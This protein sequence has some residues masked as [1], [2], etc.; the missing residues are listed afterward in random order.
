MAACL[1]VLVLFMIPGFSC[2]EPVAVDESISFIRLGEHTDVLEDKSGAMDFAYVCSDKAKSFW[3][4]SR[5]ENINFGYTDSVVWVRT[6]IVNRSSKDLKFLIE[7]GYPLLDHIHVFVMRTQTRDEWVMGDKLPFRDRPIDDPGFVCPIIVSSGE[8]VVFF[9]RVQTTSSMQIPLNLYSPEGFLEEKQITMMF[10]GLYYGS[11]VIMVLYNFFLFMSVRESDYLYYVLY[12]FFQ[13]LFLASFNG[14]SFKYF[15]PEA[16][17]W[18]DQSIVVSLSAMIVSGTMSTIRFMK[19]SKG[20]GKSYTLLTM[21]AVAAFVIMMISTVIPYRTAIISVMFL[22]VTTF[23]FGIPAVFIRWYKGFPPGR[24]FALAWLALAGGVFVLVLNKIGV[25]PRNFVTENATQLASVVQVMLLSFALAD[26]LNMEKREKIEAQ[27][28]AHE[29]ERNERIANEKAILNER[30]ARETKEAAYLIQRKAAETLEQE[31]MERTGQLNETLAK[32]K[33][34]NQQI[35]SSLRYARMIQLAIL[36]DQD[37]VKSWIPGLSIW[38]APRDIVGGDFY[39]IDQIK[40]G[41]IVA[42]ADCTGRGVAG[43]FM[44]IIAGSEL[45]RIV[46]GEECHDP[47]E[48]LARLNRR[49]RRALRQDTRRAMSDDGLNIGIC[50]VNR[51]SR[52]LWFSGA[53]IDMVYVMD[54]EIHTLKGDRKSVGYA[55]GDNLGYSVQSMGMDKRTAVF[56]YTDGITDQLGER[57]G[58]RFGTRRLKDLIVEHSRL[59]ISVQCEIIK[60]SSEVYR[61]ERDQMD[62]MTMVAFEVKV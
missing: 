58:Q 51:D 9:A 55:S 19:L 40:S 53:K 13:C 28:Q 45:K 62:D 23:I 20:S 52:T 17:G 35:M 31:V 61:G 46:K 27:H 15:W 54:G 33:D 44:T 18:N 56:I 50:V 11:M 30:L 41:F 39:F 3:T 24:F 43:A 1:N 6:G 38:W 8:T 25:V 12:V 60:A 16:T 47:G 42:V 5:S 21:F 59:P 4:D 14:L 36:P 22:V 29:E 32:V 48:I 49:V 57:S 10:Q 7:I 37:K 34:A 2:S 26:R